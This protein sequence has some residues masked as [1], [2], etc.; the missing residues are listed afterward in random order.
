MSCSKSRRTRRRVRGPLLDG[1]CESLVWSSSVVGLGARRALRTLV[2]AAPPGYAAWLWAKKYGPQPV[3]TE[4]R[5]CGSG[6]AMERAVREG[7][8]GLHHTA[9]TRRCLLDRN[10]V[11]ISM[12]SRWSVRSVEPKQSESISLRAHPRAPSPGPPLRQLGASSEA[13]SEA[14]S[15]HVSTRFQHELRRIPTRYI[16]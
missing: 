16:R 9:T 1:L 4:A 7:D 2:S 3:R 5:E 6:Y 14:E 10:R 13:R 8:T 11:R 12:S 15:C